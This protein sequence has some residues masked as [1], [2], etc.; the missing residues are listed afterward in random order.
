MECQSRIIRIEKD[1]LKGNL[2]FNTVRKVA[3]GFDM[4]FVYGFA[5]DKSIKEILYDR[6]KEIALETLN[7]VD[8][9]M[10]LEMQQL[11]GNEKEKA[12]EELVERTLQEEKNIWE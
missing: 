9:S 3:E 6:A 8:H 7:R 11:S 1:E 12:M 10:Y 5:S 4:K 2:T